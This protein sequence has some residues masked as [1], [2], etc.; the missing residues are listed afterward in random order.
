MR[1]HVFR[2]T[3]GADLK[4]SIADYCKAHAIEAGY[5][6]CCVG[7]VYE[8]Q[9]RTAGGKSYFHDVQPYE[10]V[11]L[12]GTLSKDGVHLH[13]A[14]SAKDAHTI[15]GHLMEGT[16]IDTTAEIVLQELENYTFTRVWDE[17]TGYK[18]ISIKAKD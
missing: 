12:V 16:L 11:S 10:I 9:V 15:G 5:I 8:V 3:K 13:I 2:L 7:C 4:K 14:L 6:V 1:T 17:C 18:E